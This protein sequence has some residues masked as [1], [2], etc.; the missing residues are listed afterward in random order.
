[1]SISPRCWFRPGRPYSI[2]ADLLRALLFGILV[3]FGIFRCLANCEFSFR[4][5]VFSGSGNCYTLLATFCVLSV[6][7]DWFQ[8]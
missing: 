6:F 2:A 4:I 3:V 7:C 8:S 1:M 5:F